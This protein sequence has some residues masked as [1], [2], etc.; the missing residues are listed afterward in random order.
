M[1]NDASGMPDYGSASVPAIKQ[2]LQSAEHC[3]VDWRSILEAVNI[4]PEVLEDNNKRIPGQNMERILALLIT[5]SEDPCFGLHTAQFIEPASYSVLGYININCNTLRETL[6]NTAIYEKIVGDMGVSSTHIDNG[7]VLQRW[8]CRFRDPLVRRHVIENVLGSWKRYIS[9]FGH[10]DTSL[11]D[12]VWFEHGPPEDSDMLREYSDVFDC[13]VLFNQQASGFWFKEELLDVKLPQADRKLL[14]TL[15]DH[16]T[17]IL[18]EIDRDQ[19]VN[20]RVRNLLRLMLKEREP[21]SAQI[22]ERLNMSSRTLQRKLGA[23]GT[24]YQTVLSEVRLELAL[25]YLEN[26]TLSLDRI[27]HELGYGEARSFY[28]SFKQWTGRTAGSY[29]AENA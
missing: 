24:Q 12:S 28:R 22:A 13:D 10:L 14:K 19:P 17:Q 29:R 26:T 6:A 25:Y 27:A 11:A 21:S 3:G 20:F 7:Q 5:A 16:A 23:E 2:Y 18:S 9:E 1:I 8:E 15:L 4:H